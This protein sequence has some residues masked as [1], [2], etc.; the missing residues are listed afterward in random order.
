MS[1]ATS[2]ATWQQLKELAAQSDTL[3]LRELFAKDKQRFDNF[4]LK[5]AGL[6]LDYSKNLITEEI[7]KLLLNLA[8]EVNLKEKISAMYQGDKINNTENRAV[9]HTALRK[10]N[11]EAEIQAVLDKM[12]KCSEQI[13]TGVWLGFSDKPITDIVNLGIGGSDL[14]PKMVVEALTPYTSNRIKCHFVSNVDGTHISETLKYLNP[15]TTIFII[16]SKTFTTQETLTNALTAREWLEQ[17][18]GKKKINNHLL[19][20]S[21]NPEK[22]AEF[23]INHNNIFPFWDFIGGRFSLWSAIGLPIAIAIGMDRFKDLLHGAA[24][25][26]QHFLNADYQENMPTL[27]ALIGIWN[28]NFLNCQTQAVLPYDQYLEL[29]PSYLQQLDMESNGKSIQANGEPVDC[30]TAPVIWGAAGTNGQHAFHQL[31]MQGTQK[32]P[33]DF[34]LSLKSHNPIGQ[35]HLFLYANCLAQSQAL[36]FGRTM[37][38]ITDKKLAAH[39]IVKGNVPNNIILTEKITPQTL[40]ALIALYEHKIFVQGIIWGLNSFDQWGVELGKQIAK[41]LIPLL[42]GDEIPSDID[43]STKNLIEKYCNY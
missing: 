31:L 12:E 17:K 11:P 10:D 36:A 27:L 24:S 7:L 16:A 4:S 3:N 14:G 39:K 2:T 43:C 25:M 1:E 29:L 26:D 19:A 41:K 33:V 40:G 38:E 13:R 35:H 21:A 37:E 28:R 32:I 42:E 22:A 30:A 8:E 15:E 9:L 18:A 20:V 6:L 5:T 34:I 23:G